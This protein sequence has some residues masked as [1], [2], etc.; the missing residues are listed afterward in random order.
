VVLFALGC[1][2]SSTGAP[3]APPDVMIPSEPAFAMTCQQGVFTGFDATNGWACNAIVDFYPASPQL[4]YVLAIW[5]YRF[6]DGAMWRA[7]PEGAR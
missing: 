6:S 1:A 2:E 3:P 7:L 4:G 5:F